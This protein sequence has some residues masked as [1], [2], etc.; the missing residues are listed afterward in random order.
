MNS[1]VVG[2]NNLQVFLIS[3]LLVIFFLIIIFFAHDISISDEIILK[4]SMIVDLST[5]LYGTHQ[6]LL[7]IFCMKQIRKYSISLMK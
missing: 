5:Y 3:S 1:P 6:L 7:C 2:C 4:I